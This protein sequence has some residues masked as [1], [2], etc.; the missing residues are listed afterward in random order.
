MAYQADAAAA[1]SI[2]DEAHCPITQELFR[3]PVIA[4]DGNTY[5]RNAI[6]HWLEAH[7]TSPMTGAILANTTLI[8][9]LA[10]RSLIGS[11]PEWA[12]SA[13]RAVDVGGQSESS[14]FSHVLGAA[15]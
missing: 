10:L 13:N 4:A 3:D 14:L 1:D 6:A 9:N 5:E 11:H 12:G 8:P 15:K 7:D 2:P